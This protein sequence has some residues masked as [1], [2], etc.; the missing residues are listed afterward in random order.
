MFEI[1]SILLRPA[2]ESEPE[3]QKLRGTLPREVLVN[4]RMKPELHIGITLRVMPMCSSGVLPG[5][6]IAPEVQVQFG[7]R[8]FWFRQYA[9]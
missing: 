7:L 6:N 2:P 4:T 5:L 1:K 3:L 8:A 9:L